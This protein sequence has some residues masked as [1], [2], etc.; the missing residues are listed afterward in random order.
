MRHAVAWVASIALLLGATI[1][2]V[3]HAHSPDHAEFFRSVAVDSAVALVDLAITVGVIDL[4]LKSYSERQRLRSVKP[5]VAEFF[6]EF[7]R[8]QAAHRRNLKDATVVDLERYRRA[9]AAVQRSA[10]DL[11]GLLP[12]SDSVVSS[13]LLRLSHELQDHTEIVEDAIASVRN[14]SED[15]EQWISELRNQGEA[16]FRSADPTAEA[17]VAEYHPQKLLA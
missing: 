5:R 11:H 7:Q 8:L 4:F 2:W 14:E 6:N 1:L 17:L 9:A 13:N 16:I 10:F 12:D 3:T 15:A